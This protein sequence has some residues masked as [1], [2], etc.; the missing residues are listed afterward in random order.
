[1][2]LRDQ[3]KYDDAV[4]AY[5]EAIKAKPD[6]SHAWFGLGMSYAMQGK[7]SEALDALNHLRRLDPS[8]ADK[9]AG[10]LSPK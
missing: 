8:M 3:G 7:R 10:L 9:L 1:V 6:D 4:A 5:R 2:S